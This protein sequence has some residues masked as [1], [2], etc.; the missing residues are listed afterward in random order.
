MKKIIVTLFPALFVCCHLHPQAPVQ[1]R[2][3]IELGGEK[4]SV[5]ITGK[6]DKNPVLLFIHGGPGW[7]QT[8]QLR[9]FNA[10]LLKAFILATWD[11][12]G[13]G[14]S[15]VYDSVAPDVTLEQIVSD[16]HELTQRLKNKFH[17]KRIYLAGFSWGSVV[18]LKLV[19]RYPEDYLAYV[20]ISQVISMKKGMQVSQQ[21][22]RQQAMQK[23][24][25][26]TV[27]I[28]QGL[29]G[30]DTNL[31]KTPLECFMK[32]YELVSKYH[33][34]VFNPVSDSEVQKAMTSYDDYKNYDWNKGFF[35]SATR[36]EKDMF[37]VD[38]SSLT[39]VSIPVYFIAG[40]HD[41]NVPAVLVKEFMDHLQSP[42]KEMIW[43]EHSGH[44][45]LEEE[46]Q[47][48]N[49]VMIEKLLR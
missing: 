9:Y 26:A 46:P 45:P 28:V 21:W 49:Q 25:T 16:A 6:S 36:L 7:P 42:H 32:Q 35:Y 11:Q 15:Y 22:V 33:G 1:E 12:R 19:Q 5:E 27:H 40:R 30:H 48:F 41:W 20:G 8:P 13:C 10:D 34:A 2:S 43:F 39:K 44:G 23:N 29:Q 4:Q 14:K 31:C 47:K 38:F 37:S 17:A 3:L 18:G 24:D